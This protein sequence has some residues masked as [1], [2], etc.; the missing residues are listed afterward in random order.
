MP[1]RYTTRT[2][3]QLRS[4]GNR[5]IA[6]NRVRNRIKRAAPVLGGK[7]TTN[8]FIDGHNGWIDAH[9]LGTRPPVSYSLALQTTIY[10]Y[11]ELVRSR[12]WEQSYDLAPERE[13]PLFD[14]AV[15]D[16][17]TGQIVGLRSEPLQYPELENM[18]RL[19]WAKAQ[20]QKIA[21]SGDIEVFESWTLHHGYHRGIGLHATLDVPFLTI[22]AINAFIDRFLM[23]EA[24]FFDPTPHTY[25][26]E[27]VSHW[28][29][30]SNAVI[31]PW[32]WDG[33]LKRQASQDDPSTL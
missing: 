31:E 18:T 20:H 9:F 7:F 15:K 30:E 22:E 13:L 29:L 6:F 14:G 1:I 8:S 33:A 11:K 3:F 12:A 19:Q 24:N 32:E 28:G 25:R 10:E 26:Y 21:D 4:R 23:T 5:K 16:S 2:P 17:R 27:Q